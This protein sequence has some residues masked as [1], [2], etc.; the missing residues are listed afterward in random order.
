MQE[1]DTEAARTCKAGHTLF[2]ENCKQ[3]KALRKEWYGFLKDN[4]FYDIENNKKYLDAGSPTELHLRKDFSTEDTFKAKQSY[5]SWAREMNERAEFQST[6]D[7]MIWE[8]HAEGLSR[9]KIA[10]MVGL[11]GSWVM[12]KIHRIENYIKEQM[13]YMASM[14][15]A[16]AVMATGF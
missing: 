3:C 2:L 13:S 15:S 16:S 7:K 11:E 6:R 1:T 9:R 14:S 4:G 5:Y 12:K 8:Y 10:P